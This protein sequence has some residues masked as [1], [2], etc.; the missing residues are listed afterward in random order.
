MSIQ[1]EMTSWLISLRGSQ[2]KD[3]I[4]SQKGNYITLTTNNKFM[5]HIASGYI[6]PFNASFWGQGS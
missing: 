5:R 2:L 1:A 6:Y 4:L 3:R